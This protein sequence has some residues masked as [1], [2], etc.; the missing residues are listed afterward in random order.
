[1][2]CNGSFVMLWTPLLAYDLTDDNIKSEVTRLVKKK[3]GKQVP[4]NAKRLGNERMV[5][6]RLLMSISAHLLRRPM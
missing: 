5:V 6:V 2:T 4:K 3:K 1:M